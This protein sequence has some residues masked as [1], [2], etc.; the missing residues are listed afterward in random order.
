M[1]RSR[2]GIA[3][4]GRGRKRKE[5]VARHGGRGAGASPAKDEAVC[6]ITEPQISA[7]KTTQRSGVTPETDFDRP[8]RRVTV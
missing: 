7:T 1:G 8:A 3:P 4:R 6:A 2:R 5:R